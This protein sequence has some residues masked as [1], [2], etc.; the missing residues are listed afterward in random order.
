MQIL[1][2]ALLNKN[3]KN[4]VMTSRQEPGL[5]G[6]YIPYLPDQQHAAVVEVCKQQDTRHV[7]QL[8][9]NFLGARLNIFSKRN[10]TDML[11]FLI[12]EIN[13]FLVLV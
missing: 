8:I 6:L 11:H 5:E 7:F 2:H 4:I 9:A 3:H 12:V 1:L 13:A 10:F